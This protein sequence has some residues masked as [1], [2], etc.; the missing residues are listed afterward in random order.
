V[1]AHDRSDPPRFFY[2]NKLALELFRMSA[3]QFIGLP[4]HNSAEP[5]MREERAQIFVKL[6]SD[7][8]VT[9]YTGVRIAADGTRF[10]ITD[11]V[12]WNLVDEAGRRHGQAAAIDD[13]AIL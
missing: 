6:E 13:W 1:V 3:A 2:G 7:N 4:S 11:A 5:A 12:I 10:R 9:G 8:V